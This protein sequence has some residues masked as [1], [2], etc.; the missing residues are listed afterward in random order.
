MGVMDAFPE[1]TAEIHG[2]TL[3]TLKVS[4]FPLLKAV[5]NPWSG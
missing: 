4:D 2:L 3:V 1:A 5:L